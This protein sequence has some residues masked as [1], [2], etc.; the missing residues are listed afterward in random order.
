MREYKSAKSSKIL[1]KLD[2]FAEKTKNNIYLTNETTPITGSVLSDL[3]GELTGQRVL[4]ER[5]V[6]TI[7]KDENLKILE[8]NRA[9]VL[10][11]CDSDVYVDFSR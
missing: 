4:V 10:A 8:I 9:N 6:G 11:L 7:F 3:T 2:D 5:N 1:V